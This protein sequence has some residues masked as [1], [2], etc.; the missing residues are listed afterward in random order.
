M[1]KEKEIE[2]AFEAT[3]EEIKDYC[4]KFVDLYLAE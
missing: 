3:R 4:E 2:A 1:I